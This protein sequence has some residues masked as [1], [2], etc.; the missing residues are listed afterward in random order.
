MKQ[1]SSVRKY[2]TYLYF[3]FYGRQP[4]KKKSQNISPEVSLNVFPKNCSTFFSKNA[5]HFCKS[6]FL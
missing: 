4:I 1:D 5:L 3:G 2:M 6:Q